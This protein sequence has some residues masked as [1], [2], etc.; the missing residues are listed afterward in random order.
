MFWWVFLLAQRL[1]LATQALSLCQE[2][3]VSP[4]GEPSLLGTDPIP[5]GTNP[6]PGGM[7]PSG[8][9]ISAQTVLKSHTRSANATLKFSFSFIKKNSVRLENS[10]LTVTLL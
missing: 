2:Q 3:L 4:N 9:W 6:I 5:I 7:V 10:A 1:A 8:P